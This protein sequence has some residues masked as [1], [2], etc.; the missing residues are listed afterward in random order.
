MKN[1]K[2]HI[3]HL[4]MFGAC[5]FWGLMAPLGKDAMTNGLDGLTMVSLRVLGWSASLYQLQR[6][7]RLY[8]W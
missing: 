2:A 4:S 7:G 3:A 8:M 1:S 6:G 5:A